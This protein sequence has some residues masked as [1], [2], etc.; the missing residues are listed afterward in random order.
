MK[1]YVK[2]NFVCPLPVLTFLSKKYFRHSRFKT[3]ESWESRENVE[4]QQRQKV[5]RE[6]VSERSTGLVNRMV[7]ECRGYRIVP[8]RLLRIFQGL[9]V[10][11]APVTKC[12]P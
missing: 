8:G 4:R 1:Y 2:I 9:R 7:D 12:W 11:Q 5:R 3:V 6:V 10:A